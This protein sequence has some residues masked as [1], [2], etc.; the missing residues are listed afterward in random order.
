MWVWG[1]IALVVLALVYVRLA[2][3]DPARWHAIETARAEVGDYPGQGRFAAVREAGPEAFAALVKVADAAARTKRVAGSEDEG[4]LT[5]QTRSQL[6]GF[7]DFTTLRY[8]GGRLEAYARL[9][10]GRDD[11]GVNKARV[12]DWFKAAGIEG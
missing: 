4:M 6:I 8:D 5:Y 10:F 2:P 1:L 9:R 3:A 7:P 11:F 12:L